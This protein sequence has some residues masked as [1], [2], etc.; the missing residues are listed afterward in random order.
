LTLKQHAIAICINAKP[1]L[2]EHDPTAHLIE[3][4]EVLHNK[5]SFLGIYKKNIQEDGR[6]LLYKSVKEDNTDFYSGKIK[7]AGIVE[8]PDWDADENR[9]CGGGFHLSP[10]ESLARSYNNGK[11]KKCLV[12][13]IDFVVHPH[14]ITKVRCRK[15]EVLED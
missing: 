14:D 9:Q 2:I 13:L 6:I 11:I 7:Y 1:K 12:R 3:S 10:T 4:P 8:C 15:V 5:K